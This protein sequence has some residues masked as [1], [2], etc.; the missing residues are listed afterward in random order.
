[1]MMS[2]MN[3]SLMSPSMFSL[4][5]DQQYAPTQFSIG[6]ACQQWKIEHVMAVI[7]LAIMPGSFVCDSSWMNYLLA[8]SLA[9]HA[10]WGEFVSDTC[11]LIDRHCPLFNRYERTFN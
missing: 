3:D 6:T 11:L 9:V 1:M 10:H 8:I 7:M 2:D 5:V 4:D